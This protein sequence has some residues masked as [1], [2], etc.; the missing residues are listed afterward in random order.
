[1]ESNKVFIGQKDLKYYFPACFFALGKSDTIK[2]VARGKNTKKALD[3]L[4]ILKREYLESPKYSIEIDSEKFID[5]NNDGKER[6][7][8][9]IEIELSGVR[10]E[11]NNK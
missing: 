2:I 8:T 11:R 9:T 10:K 1:M 4:A 6:H 7:V 3:L 5:E